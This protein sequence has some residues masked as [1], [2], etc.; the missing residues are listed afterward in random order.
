MEAL[1]ITRFLALVAFFVCVIGLGLHLRTL[2]A[3]PYIR[4]V[5]PARGKVWPGV[6]YAFTLGMAPW[7]EESGR[8]HPFLYFRG[9]VFHAGIF[10]ALFVLVISPWLPGLAWL[11]YVLVF[12]VGIGL[13]AG[14]IGVLLRLFG[15][16]ERALSTLDDLASVIL[17]TLFLASAFSALLNLD[18]LPVFYVVSSL[19]LIYIPFSKLRHLIYF[20]FS[21]FFFGVRFGW[22]GILEWSEVHLGRAG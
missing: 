15:E 4:E 22:R 21:R 2:M 17:V 18:W 13:L 6:A 19:M 14:L 10:A 20:F 1:I 3:L 11:R 12:L 8:L 16:R 5:A 7:K 9:V